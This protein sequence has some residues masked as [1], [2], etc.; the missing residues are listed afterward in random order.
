MQAENTRVL[1]AEAEAA[2]RE[3]LAAN[4]RRVLISLEKIIPSLEALQRK[5]NSA[6]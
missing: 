1:I 6:A 4:H 3:R 2:G 5:E